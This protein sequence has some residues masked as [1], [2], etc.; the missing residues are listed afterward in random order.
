MNCRRNDV[1]LRSSPKRQF[2]DLLHC[3]TI[4]GCS[5]S[6]MIGCSVQ[7]C[8]YDSAIC[9]SSLWSVLLSLCPRLIARE[10]TISDLVAFET[11][12]P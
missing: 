7:Q 11:F 9:V 2:Y 3:G 8:V 10:N 6:L 1:K 5:Q 12:V 4:K